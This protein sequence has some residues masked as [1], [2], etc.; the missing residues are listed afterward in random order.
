MPEWILLLILTWILFWIW[1]RIHLH[2]ISS[3]RFNFFF[4]VPFFINSILIFHLNSLAFFFREF[5]HGFLFEFLPENSREFPREFFWFFFRVF[6][7]ENS[8]MNFVANQF[9][10]DFLRKVFLKVLC[11]FCWPEVL[12][13]I[14]W[15]CGHMYTDLRVRSWCDASWEQRNR[16]R[17]WHCN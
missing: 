10:H 14:A 7:F 12:S 13:R 4:L 9:A 1:M 8:L 16:H 3:F 6:P 17:Y 15:V 5:S 2:V 11:F